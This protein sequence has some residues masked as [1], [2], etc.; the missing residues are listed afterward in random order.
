MKKLILTGI[1]L[2]V[3]V[4]MS[5]AQQV[6]PEEKAKQETVVLTEKLTLTEEQQQPVYDAILQGEVSKAALRADETLS[7]EV[8][9]ESLTKVQANT[10]QQVGDKLSDEQKA[11]YAQIVAERPA[12]E[13]P[14]KEAPVKEENAA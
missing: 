14:A 13:A 6:K 9:I 1:S 11:I 12:E 2:L 10:D 5:F 3:A 4:T 8:L 7:P